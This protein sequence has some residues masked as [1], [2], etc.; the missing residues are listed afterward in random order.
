MTK[1]RIFSLL[2]IAAVVGSCAPAEEEP[3]EPMMSFFLTSA[4]PG[5]G[6]ALGGLDG[7]DA[8]CQSLANSVE[9]DGTW[10]AY[11]SAAA[12]ADAAAVNARDRIGT[13]PWLNRALVEV[14]SDV[15]NLHSENNNLTKE[16]VLNE[17]GGMTN[18]RGDTP[19]R[20]DILTGSNL[21]GTVAEGDGD[22]TCDNWTSS[23]EGSALVGHFDREGGGANP[24]SWNSAH[25]SSGC[26]QENLQGTGGAGLFYCFAV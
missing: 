15:A 16:T 25:P 19:N 4:G 9:A 17:R 23:G 20:H 24:T 22:T 26:S 10:H 13:G 3:M 12:T 8:Y 2:T 21:D 18:G 14:A 5:D 7:A 6:A 11:L 1:L